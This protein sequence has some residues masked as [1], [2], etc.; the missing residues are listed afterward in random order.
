M[1]NTSLSN[2]DLATALSFF[3]LITL[4]HYQYLS[5]KKK[6]MRGLG[7]G[8]HLTACSSSALHT[9]PTSSAWE[10]L[11]L[12]ITGCLQCSSVLS[13][14]SHS[15]SSSRIWRFVA[16]RPISPGLATL[17]ALT[18]P[19]CLHTTVAALRSNKSSH[20]VPHSP[21]TKISTRPR[22]DR[23]GSGLTSLTFPLRDLLR[24]PLPLLW[25]FFL[26]FTLPLLGGSD[27]F[28][29]A[30]VQYTGLVVVGV[31]GVVIEAV[32]YGRVL[33]EAC[34][35]LVDGRNVVDGGVL[36][37]VVSDLTFRVVMYCGLSVVLWLRIGCPIPTDAWWP[38][39]TVGCVVTGLKV[40]FGWAG[41]RGFWVSVLGFWVGALSLGFWVSILGDAVV[42]FLTVACTMAELGV[43]IVLVFGEVVVV[44]FLLITYSVKK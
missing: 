4:Y 21:L 3:T 26:P 25:P 8:H 32:Q 10:Q 42:G 15:T 22:S 34:G 24:P 44:G 6:I 33:L 9:T 30:E 1:I 14:P 36:W 38:W 18:K 28:R 5:V 37:G 40:G 20:T 31:V 23:S 2:C 27:V 35:C 43:V 29:E 7:H 12:P 17:S 13:V 19:S 11:C 39:R 41:V 16:T